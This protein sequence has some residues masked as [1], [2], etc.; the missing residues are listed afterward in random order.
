M[1][2]PR[3][4]RRQNYSKLTPRFDINGT[5]YAT[6]DNMRSQEMRCNAMAM[7]LRPPLAGIRVLDLSRLLPGPFATL[8]LAEW[9]AEIW[10]VESPT[11]PDYLRFWGSSDT[12]K[13]DKDEAAHQNHPK[14]NVGFETLNR[15]KKS[16]VIAYETEVGQDVLKRLLAECDVLVESFRAG[17]LKRLGLDYPSL[18]A[19]G[20]FP[21]LIYA[22]LTA[23]GQQSSR[24]SHDINCLALS[25]LSS[26]LAGKNNG[27]IL[28]VPNVQLVDTVCGMEASQAI[29]AALL[30]RAT[31]HNNSGGGGCYLDISMLEAAKK[32]NR[33]NLATT[34]GASY[35]GGLL[36]GSQPF[37]R[38]Y[39]CADDTYLAVG[40]VEAK[41]QNLILEAL[42]LESWDEAES[43]FAS[44]P[45]DH[46]MERLSALDACV[47]PALEPSEALDYDDNGKASSTEYHQQSCCFPLGQHTFEILQTHLGYSRQEL[48]ALSQ[49]GAISD[50]GYESSPT[51]MAG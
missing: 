2:Q 32:L 3:R 45:R 47:E 31:H 5:R 51:G 9:G 46:W 42:E 12:T 15:G 26:A 39:R 28:T 23:F 41:F 27:G 20:D 29:L 6:F 10:K 16:L 1:R 44:Q 49:V 33:L 48:E 40:A 22:S 24:A 8:Q 37:Y 50:F 38:Y 36:D 21:Q 19:S 4:F 11:K 13:N 34:G 14:M 30:S 7:K 25:G 43:K 35:H 18:I 17:Y